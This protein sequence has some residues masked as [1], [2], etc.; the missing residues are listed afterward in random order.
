MGLLEATRNTVTFRNPH[1]ASISETAHLISSGSYA[2][3]LT[4]VRAGAAG[5][6]AAGEEEDDAA[7]DGGGGGL[8]R[9]HQLRRGVRRTT[10]EAR[11]TEQPRDTH[12]QGHPPLRGPSHHLWLLRTKK[13]SVYTTR[14]PD[15]C[16]ELTSSTSAASGSPLFGDCEGG[17][18][19]SLELLSHCN[20]EGAR[21]ERGD[22]SIS[23]R[24]SRG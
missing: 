18:L 15:G 17:R 20:L 2:D 10:C 24:P 13:R 5:S 16:V 23:S 12:R 1:G 22:D 9:Q 19:A 4:L 7:T 11:C 21:R 3:G 14:P 6:G 8:H